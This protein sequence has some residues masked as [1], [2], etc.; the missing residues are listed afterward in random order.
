MTYIFAYDADIDGDGKNEEDVLITPSSQQKY[1]FVADIFKK[2]PGYEFKGWQYYGIGFDKN[3]DIRVY[4]STP[5]L[6][7]A[8]RKKYTVITVD[9]NGKNFIIKNK[10]YGEFKYVG[11]AGNKCVVEM[12]A[13]SI[14][15]HSL[16]SWSFDPGADAD[17]I[18]DVNGN[19][20]GPGSILEFT[21]GE[22]DMT[23]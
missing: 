6:H 1:T 8:W 19:I 5:T 15:L 7:A 13:V 14:D 12:K 21:L 9:F 4:E 18:R 16:K 22:E 23:V 20:I 3:T 11:F 2:H 10:K 17:L